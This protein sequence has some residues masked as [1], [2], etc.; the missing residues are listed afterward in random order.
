VNLAHT[1]NISI[2][3]AKARDL[4]SLKPAWSV[5]KLHRET[6]SPIQNKKESNK[7]DEFCA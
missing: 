7:A 1:L 5:P 6:P 3:E 2:Q 4:L